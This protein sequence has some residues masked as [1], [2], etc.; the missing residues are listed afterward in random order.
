MDEY[1]LICFEKIFNHAKEPE[2][3]KN[4]KEFRD[5]IQNP[6]IF[7]GCVLSFYSN[8]LK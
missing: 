5:L 6:G 4:I 3:I 1:D 2:V 7:A 8:Q